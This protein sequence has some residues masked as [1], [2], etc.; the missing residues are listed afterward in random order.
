MDFKKYIAEKTAPLCA[1]EESALYNLLEKPKDETMGDIAFPCFTL[2]KTLR[3]APNMI[4]SELKDKI[5]TG[6]RD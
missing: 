4:A 5:G 1:M 2:S 3:K 6:R